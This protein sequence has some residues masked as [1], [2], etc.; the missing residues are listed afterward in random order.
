MVFPSTTLPLSFLPPR[1]A[2]CSRDIRLVVVYSTSVGLD[3]N[4][5]LFASFFV[6]PHRLI[7]SATHSDQYSQ[8]MNTTISKRSST[9]QSP[10]VEIDVGID[11]F[12]N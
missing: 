12:H 5:N 1:V 8:H 11:S 9:K 3:L 2:H 7:L 10:A 4:V 6:F